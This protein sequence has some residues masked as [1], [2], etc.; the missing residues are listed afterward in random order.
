ML[1]LPPSIFFSISLSETVHNIFLFLWP[2]KNNPQTQQITQGA[3]NLHGAWRIH[4]LITFTHETCLIYTLRSGSFDY[5]SHYTWHAW[6][7]K[8]FFW[9]V[10]TFP[11]KLGMICASWIYGGTTQHV[12]RCIDTGNGSTYHWL[13]LPLFPLGPKNIYSKSHLCSVKVSQFHM[14]YISVPL[15]VVES[16]WSSSI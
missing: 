9:G 15:A 8:T 2:F 11:N 12:L 1:T 4:G 14:F 3:R 7:A 5:S 10:A 16:T 13:I 6:Q